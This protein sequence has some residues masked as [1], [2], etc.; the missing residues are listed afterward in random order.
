MHALVQDSV[1]GTVIEA[2]IQ[3]LRSSLLNSAYG[4]CLAEVTAAEWWAHC[5]EP[6]EAHQ[7]HFDVKEAALRQGLQ[8]YQLQHPV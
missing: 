3:E 2:A 4:A 1:P 8:H 5:R 6:D 7:L